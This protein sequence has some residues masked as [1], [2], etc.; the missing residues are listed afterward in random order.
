[1]Y[2]DT[3]DLITKKEFKLGEEVFYEGIQRRVISVSRPD[4]KIL[5]SG[6]GPAI[7]PEKIQPLKEKEDK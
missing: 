1:M 2:L 7:P 6:I 5:L 4:G 3:M